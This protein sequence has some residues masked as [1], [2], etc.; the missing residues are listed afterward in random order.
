M[1]IHS[2]TLFGGLH[3]SDVSQNFM[4]TSMERDGRVRSPSPPPSPRQPALSLLASPE[5]KRRDP[6]PSRRPN[7]QS[8]SVSQPQP[9]RSPSAPWLRLV[10]PICNEINNH[11]P[12]LCTSVVATYC[13]GSK[14]RGDARQWCICNSASVSCAWCEKAKWLARLRFSFLHIGGVLQMCCLGTHSALSSGENLV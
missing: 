8:T 3:W 9:A 1:V 11:V 7:T 2:G 4:S 13:W 14:T 5:A 6:S 12:N 10:A